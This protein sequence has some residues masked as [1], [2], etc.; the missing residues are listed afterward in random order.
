MKN[1]PQSNKCS[2]Y[3]PVTCPDCGKTE[4]VVCPV[5]VTNSETQLQHGDCCQDC[6]T[7]REIAR[8]QNIFA[9]FTS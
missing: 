3:H 1:C 4:C 5:P 8:I 9:R 2:Q 7:K 6:N